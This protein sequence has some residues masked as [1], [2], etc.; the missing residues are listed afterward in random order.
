MLLRK[1]HGMVGKI[2]GIKAYIVG[3]LPEVIVGELEYL[4]HHLVK[5]FLR[6][7]KELRIAPAEY[8]AIAVR[9]CGGVNPFGLEALV[10]L[11]THQIMFLSLRLFIVA[12]NGLT[13]L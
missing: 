9:R 7:F 10:L 6:K 4:L 3:V 8:R 11:M 12:Y 13:F 1:L 2:D 5:R